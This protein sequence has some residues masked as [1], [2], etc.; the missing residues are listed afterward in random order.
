VRDREREPE[1]GEIY[2]NNFT[3][4]NIKKKKKTI[5]SKEKEKRKRKMKAN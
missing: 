1:N 4:M 3:L 5:K 2:D